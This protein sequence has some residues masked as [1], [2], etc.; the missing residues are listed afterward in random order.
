MSRSRVWAVCAGL[1]IVLTAAP[2]LAAPPAC[3]TFADPP[4]DSSYYLKPAR[5]PGEP[6]LDLV[7]VRFGVT[8]DAVVLT[9][10][11][12][13]LTQ[14][15]RGTGD[16]TEFGFR[17]DGR[18]VTVWDQR[19]PARDHEGALSPVRGISVDGRV[20]A[21]SFPVSYTD[22]SSTITF[23]IPRATLKSMGAAID[24]RSVSAVTAERSATLLLVSTG[25]DAA[26]SGA[27]VKGV[28]CR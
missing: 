1:G 8:K 18:Q 7:R 2:G 6:A 17:L 27:A 25:Y 24:N 14:T 22:A 11:V 12:Q 23:T 19:G 13:Q 3:L 15:T 16:R 5:V 26:A 28:V 10:T 20:S 21:Q 9:A 4:G